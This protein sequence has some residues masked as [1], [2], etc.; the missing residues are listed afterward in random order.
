MRVPNPTIG[1]MSWFVAGSAAATATLNWSAPNGTTPTGYKIST[2]LAGSLPD[3]TPDY[4]PSNSFYTAR[5]SATPPFLQAS[6]TYV[7]LITAILDGAAD[8]ETHPN[9]SALPTASAIVV[10]A[11]ITISQ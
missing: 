10:S 4:I 1:G 9:R 8:F 5:T 2:F 7:F 11:P 3:G 6:K